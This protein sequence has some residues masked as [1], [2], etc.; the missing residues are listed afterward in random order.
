MPI[1][2]SPATASPDEL[3]VAINDHHNEIAA[4]K[5]D[6][7]DVMAAVGTLKSTVAGH[8]DTLALLQAGSRVV[9]DAQ[10]ALP[11]LKAWAQQVHVW[12]R[13]MHAVFGK[14]HNVPPPPPA[15]PGIAPAP[16]A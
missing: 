9:D 15:P 4:L 11:E 2:P 7:S 3:G 6:I 16:S 8:G 5:S 12:V 14:H 13:S 1:I 10:A